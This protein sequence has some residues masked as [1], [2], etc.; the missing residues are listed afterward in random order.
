MENEL[1][2]MSY[3]NQSY[4][5]YG[6]HL[7]KNLFS[8]TNRSIDISHM[9]SKEVDLLLVTTVLSYLSAEITALIRDTTTHLVKKKGN[10]GVVLFTKVGEKGSDFLKWEDINGYISQELYDDIKIKY[11][12]EIK[13]LQI[14]LSQHRVQVVITFK[15]EL[16]EKDYLQSGVDFEKWVSAYWVAQ[17][18]CNGQEY[19]VL[20]GVVK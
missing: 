4:G 11:N 17:V 10:L 1:Q 9:V 3:I 6:E 19:F 18:R 13:T 8:I 16:T 2:N 14:D 5:G 12:E 15:P 20:T 7:I